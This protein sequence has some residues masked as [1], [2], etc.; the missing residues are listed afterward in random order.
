MQDS[1][2]LCCKKYLLTDKINYINTH[3]DYL[4]LYHFQCPLNLSFNPPAT[5]KL[6]EGILQ[7]SLLTYQCTQTMFM[8]V[9]KL[10]FIKCYFV[11]SGSGP[12]HLSGNHVQ[13]EYKCNAL[14][15]LYTVTVCCRME[16]ISVWLCYCRC[17]RT[18]CKSNSY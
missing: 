18:G 8:D 12:V 13:S 2:C 1:L 6:I 7:Y 10:H 15:W 14:I 3:I 9:L 5:F 11:L 17:T 4:F 16:S